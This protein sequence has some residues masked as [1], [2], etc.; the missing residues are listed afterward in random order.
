MQKTAVPLF[1]RCLVA[2]STLI[3][4][5][6][7]VRA[8]DN[9]YVKTHYIKKDVR[10]PMRDG[11]KLYTVIYIPKDSTENYPILM[12]RTPYSAGP[13]GED[14]YARRIGP[15]TSLMKEKYIFVYQDVRGR[16][17]SEG[18]FREMTPNDPT[19]KTPDESSDAFDTI[20][21]L[22]ANL[23]HQNGRVGLYGISYPGFYAT[24]SLPDAHPAIKAVSPQ[25][26]VTDEF[27]GDD[28]NHK[29]AFF[30]MDNF[31]FMSYFDAPRTGPVEDY[32]SSIVTERY[33]DAYAFFLQLGPLKNTLKPE[34]Y[35]K[36]N[37][38]FKEYLTH[39]TYDEYWKARNIRAHLKNVKPAT[40]IVGGLFD[41]EDLFGAL[42]TYRAIEQQ[43]PVNKNTIVMG[44]WTHGAWA[45]GNWEKYAGQNFGMNTSK[46]FQD[47]LETP[48]FNYYLKDKGSFTMP[49]AV[50][51]ET[52]SNQWR[53][54]DVW[55]AKNVR[56]TSFY[57]L[58]KHKLS[59][60]KKGK[61][62]SEYTPDPGNPV[63][64]T[65][66][67][68][69]GRNNEY[70][71]EDQ[72]FASKRNDVLWF[73]TDTLK[74]PLTVAGKVTADLQVS[75]TGSDA[76]FIVKLIDVLPDGTQ[77]L[78]R[79]EVMR[80]KF[81]NSFEQPE[82][83]VPGKISNVRF[84]LPDASH[85]FLPGHRLMVQV[86]SSW[87]PLVDRNPQRFMRIAEADEMDYQKQTIR[88]YGTSK[89]TLETL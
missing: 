26:P 27:M 48:F 56:T 67:T 88:V 14:K 16:Y 69:S 2:V 5:A 45:R 70:M 7:T 21:W 66:A 60:K 38:I 1:F 44:P 71:A 46:Y 19:H 86:Q 33:K 54:Y 81:R 68:M 23:T 57:L 9:D 18:N 24:A 72:R 3:I 15:N 10:I 8:Q 49:E 78:V 82:A 43:N 32:G 76:D 74:A 41:P 35:G 50:I 77:R 59:E 89:I 75:M 85:Q 73:Q 25:A 79:A 37:G 62:Y 30:L 80:G 13:Y 40:L 83:F 39:D 51:F 20:E 4:L 22:L 63:P 29:G 87:F 42:E 58:P 34:Y 84:E 53:K 11:V 17:M 31:G 52:G 47:S 36:T 12:E 64:Y 6:S 65:A 55:P 61:A 28:A